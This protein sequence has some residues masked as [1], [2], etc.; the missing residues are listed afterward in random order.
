MVDL[1]LVR[2][3]IAEERGSAWPDD[4]LRPLTAKGIERWEAGAT[5]LLSVFRPHVVL[6]S[7]LV[8]ARQTAALLANAGGGLAIVEMDS[9]ADDDMGAVA[10]DVRATGAA[11]VAVVGHEP[12]MSQLLAWAITPGGSVYVDFKKAA[13][14][15]VH[16]DGPPEEGAGTLQWF[17][18]PSVLRLLGGLTSPNNRR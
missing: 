18:S 7:P 14:A 15:M 17:L 16:F 12:W 6:T 8:R 11:A 2:H 3:G 9:L 13:A 4:R 1:C 10:R 5:G